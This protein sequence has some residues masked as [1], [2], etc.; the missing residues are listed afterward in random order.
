MKET[1]VYALLSS[2]TV[3]ELNR[4]RRFLESPYF[5]RNEQIL[6]LFY[7]LETH[8]RAENEEDLTK[9][10]LWPFIYKEDIY[11]DRR[12][13][14]LC[15]DLLD[16]GEEYLAQEAYNENP[17][18]QA[19]YLL[20][21]VHR[22]QIERMY[23][24]ATSSAKSL[25][26][27]QNLKP[28]SYYYYQYEIEKNLYKLQNI[29]VNRASKENIQKINLETIV[30]NLDYFYIS[31]KLK[32]YCTL[33]SW[34]KIIALDKNILFIDEIIQIAT[35][36]EFKNIPP[37]AIY[38]KIYYTNVEFENE[39]HFFDLKVL[40]SNYIDL[41][42]IEEAKD[43]MDSAINYSIQKSNKGESKYLVQLFELYKSS[44]EK[45]IIFVNNQITPWSFKNIVTAA[46]RLNEFSWVEDFISKYSSRINKSYRHNAYNY[47]L[48][49]LFFYKKEFSKVIPLLQ[50]VE[51][52]E[53]YYSLSAKCMLL[54][55]YYELDEYNALS[56]FGD[57]FKL[58][59]GRNKNVAESKKVFY[60]NL[61]KFTKKLYDAKLSDN[62]YL[63]KLKSDIT[64]ANDVFSKEW[65]LEK[66]EELITN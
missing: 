12:F 21:A 13:R 57:S 49:N 9:E 66:V 34:S 18:H 30:S 14:K 17:L 35:Q 15:T 8:I 3:I 63:L 48:A 4:F 2:L 54:A 53:V 56:S 16:L 65:L 60:L 24:S 11:D 1:K 55:T 22:K 45:E 59:I 37:I 7:A 58:Y 39:N 32:Y 64:K 61:I 62:T 41:F 50:K 5:N 10:I 28:A 44:I 23:N 31:E 51:Y 27:R 29:E 40:I 26:Q 43:I 6:A 38:L 52:D 42:P 36:D 46:L 19:N 33:L 25:S 47:N 20:E